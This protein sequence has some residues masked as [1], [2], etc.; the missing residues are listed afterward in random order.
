MCGRVTVYSQT[1]LSGLLSG[2][3]ECMKYE[4]WSVEK[5]TVNRPQSTAFNF[6]FQFLIFEI[7]IIW[8]EGPRSKILKLRVRTAHTYWIK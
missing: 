3:V 5:S 2:S 1:A 8:Y 7:R 4:V 6:P